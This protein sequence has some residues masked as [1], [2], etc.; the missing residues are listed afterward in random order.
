MTGDISSHHNGISAYVC[1][2]RRHYLRLC[3]KIVPERRFHLCVFTCVVPPIHRPFMTKAVWL[4]IVTDRKSVFSDRWVMSCKELFALVHIAQYAWDEFN[5]EIKC[6][7]IVFFIFYFF[8]L[9]LEYFKY[10]VSN[11]NFKKAAHHLMYWYV[12]LSIHGLSLRLSV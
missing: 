12:L 11:G 5:W 10:W 9:D 1:C 6:S 8:R 2:T 4:F 3:Q 7:W